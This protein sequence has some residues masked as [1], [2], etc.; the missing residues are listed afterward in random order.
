MRAQGGICFLLRNQGSSSV[1]CE[2]PEKRALIRHQMCQ[3]LDLGTSQPPELGD[4]NTCCVSHPV[5]GIL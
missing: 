3:H 5:C 1:L 4:I 2:D